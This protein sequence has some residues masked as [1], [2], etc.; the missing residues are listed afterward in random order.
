MKLSFAKINQELSG[1]EVDL[2][3]DDGLRYGDWR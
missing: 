1:L 2:L 3:A